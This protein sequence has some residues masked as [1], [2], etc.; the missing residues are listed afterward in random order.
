MSWIKCGILCWSHV[1]KFALV[2]AAVVVCGV[3]V[4]GVG[5]TGRGDFRSVVFTL[6]RCPRIATRH[7]FDNGLISQVCLGIFARVLFVPAF[8]SWYLR[9]P[10][11]EVSSAVKPASE[12]VPFV[13]GRVSAPS[14]LLAVFI[15]M[16]QRWS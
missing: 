2:V 3:A 5:R 11:Q 1:S 12:P 13:F 7:R 9:F 16:S 15:Q 6:A 14:R 4:V 8:L 10:H